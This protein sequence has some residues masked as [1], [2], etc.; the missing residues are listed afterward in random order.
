MVKLH[1]IWR[2][3]ISPSFKFR[4]PYNG[5]VYTYMYIYGGVLEWEYANSWMVYFMENPKKK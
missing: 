5:F 3:G 2:V 1:D 4:I